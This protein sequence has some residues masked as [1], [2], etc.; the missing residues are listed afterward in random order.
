MSGSSVLLALRVT[1][2]VKELVEKMASD[3]DISDAVFVER[4]VLEEASRRRL[5]SPNDPGVALMTLE[6]EQ[7]KYLD[8]V[9]GKH[10]EHVTRDWFAHIQATPLLLK[11]HERAIQPPSSKISAE[12]RRQFVHQRLGRLSKQYLGLTSLGEVLL[13]LDSGALIRSYTRLG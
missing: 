4:V 2:Q 3:D 10:D 1:N 6:K 5:V 8:S 7:E 13:P 12:K 11:L 9:R